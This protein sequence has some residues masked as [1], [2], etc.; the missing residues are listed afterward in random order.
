MARERPRLPPSSQ[1]ITPAG[2]RRL[3]DELDHLWRVERPHVTQAVQEAAAMGD[4]SENAEYI[5]GK[6]RLREIDRRVRFLRKR[7]DG[8]VVVG[9]PPSRSDR[10]FFAAWVELS[11]NDQLLHWH[12]IV[13]PDEFD[14]DPRYVSMDSPLGKALFG[15]S[16]DQTVE[17]KTPQG[18]RNLTIERIHYGD[19]PPP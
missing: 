15:K 16:L 10:V 11:E 6:R 3:R 14:H 9:S 19:A 18:I 13:G 8:M 2:E 12:R 4:R 5:Y 1:Y 17:L 7:L